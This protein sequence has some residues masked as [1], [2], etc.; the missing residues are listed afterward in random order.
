MK[1]FKFQGHEFQISPEGILFWLEKEIAIVA[2]LHLEK[3][4][5]Y[6]SG[7]QFIPPY[8]SQET[9][10]NLI[11]SI[12]KNKVSELILVGDIFHDQKALERMSEDV[13]S[14]LKSLIKRY[15]TIFIRGNHDTSLILEGA[16][17]CDEYVLENIHFV[18]E[19]SEKINN[20]ISGHFHPV[21][22]LKIHSQ[23]ILAKCLVVSKNSIILPSYGKYTGGLNINKPPL[24][25]F[26]NINSIIYLLN[27]SS[28]YKIPLNQMKDLH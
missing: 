17:C 8:D 2:D 14:L 6:A 9:L 23:K 20:Q 18:H 3:G 13:R 22:S 15:K 7:G 26:I 4:S 1:I 27:K 24:K 28:V 5:S 10:H 19:A 21:A 12:E 25:K 11:N 16:Y